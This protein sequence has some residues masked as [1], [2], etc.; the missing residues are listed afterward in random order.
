ML[1]AWHA[2]VDGNGNAL[3]PDR[4]LTAPDGWPGLVNGVGGIDPDHLARARET[5]LLLSGPFSHFAPSVDVFVIF[6]ER[7]MTPV[8][9]RRNGDGLDPAFKNEKGDG[10]V[11]ARLTLSFLGQAFHERRL[12]LNG[13]VDSHAF[14]CIDTNVQKAIKQFLAG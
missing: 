10:L 12:V 6:G 5:Q 11:P 9:T 14:L 13:N 8:A 2:V 3:P 4:Q 1:P 7:Q